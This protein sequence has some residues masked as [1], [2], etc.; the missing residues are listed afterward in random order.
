MK[1]VFIVFLFFQ[2]YSFLAQV[3]SC[4]SVQISSL[5]LSSNSPTIELWVRNTNLDYI[6]YPGFIMFDSH[7]DTLA[8]ESIFYFGIGSNF[9]VH[10]LDILNP[11]NLPISGNLELHSWF[12]DSLVCTFP[13]TMDSI[14]R[15]DFSL[16]NKIKIFPNPTKDNINLSLDYFN[17]NIRTEV[18]DLN[19]KLLET[20]Y[21]TNLS[22]SDCPIGVY[23]LKVAYGARVE[24]VKIIKE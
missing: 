20:T 7:G 14:L 21:N 17:G 10:H 22:L 6:A 13:Y 15:I 2:T 5:E 11:I 19:G 24:E 18:Y 12:Y 23:L 3:F 9:Q 16:T 1:K 8:K 4:D